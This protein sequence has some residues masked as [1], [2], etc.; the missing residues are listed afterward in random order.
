MAQFHTPWVE[1]KAAV[2]K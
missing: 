1:Q 2:T